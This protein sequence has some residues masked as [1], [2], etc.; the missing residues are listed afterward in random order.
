[1]VPHELCDSVKLCKWHE[2]LG[3]RRGRL[4]QTRSMRRPFVGPLFAVLLLLTPAVSWAAPP[5]A[6]LMAK[7]GDYATKFERQRTHASYAVAGHMDMLDSDGAVDET[8]D[9]WG[10]VE[11][12]GQRA[13]LTVIRYVD[14]GKDKTEEGIK[15]SREAAEREKKKRESGKE[16]KM[17][18]RADEQARY[19]FDQTEVDPSDPTRVR[20]TFVPK[21]RG[22]DTV[23]G[24]AWVDSVTGAPIS[25]GFKLSRTPIFVDYI[26]FSVEF[27]A[28]TSL[29]PAVSKVLVEGKGGILFFRKHFRASALL[30]DYRILP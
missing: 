12:D 17:P 30:S 6:D 26:H 13:R 19:I 23:E 1:M 9:L 3:G 10:H 7:L 15:E 21:E 14:D 5:S 4:A 2:V 11:A 29:G 27:G 16:L 8:K 24:S 28:T 18:I 25:A 22:E 20:I